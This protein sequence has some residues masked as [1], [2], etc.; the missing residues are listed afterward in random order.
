MKKNSA[1]GHVCVYCD[2]P[3]EPDTYPPVC[4]EHANA[5]KKKASSGSIETLKELEVMEG[6]HD[7]VEYSE[8]VGDV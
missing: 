8:H 3:A 4:S 7:N 5:G 6:G 2:R 1:E